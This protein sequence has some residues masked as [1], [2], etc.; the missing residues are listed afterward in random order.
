MYMLP[1]YQRQLKMKMENTNKPFSREE[2]NT[3]AQ[4]TLQSANMESYF[5]GW[6]GPIG[7]EG[8]SS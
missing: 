3:H 7:V 5:H 1:N 4:I 6:K 8:V 2:W